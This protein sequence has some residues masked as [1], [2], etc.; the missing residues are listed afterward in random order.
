MKIPQLLSGH[1]ELQHIKIIILWISSFR[2]G[3]IFV[4]LKHGHL[5]MLVPHVYKIEWN[6]VIAIMST[7]GGCL[8][9]T[10]NIKCW[11]TH[12]KQAE[13]LKRNNVHIHSLTNLLVYAAMT[14]TSFAKKVIGRLAPHHLRWIKMDKTD[15]V[16]GWKKRRDQ[17]RIAVWFS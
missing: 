1:S 13:E 8:I 14:K 11:Y 10:I 3:I 16:C 2:S 12:C 6:Y 4:T 17:V 15:C 5:T 7:S 9:Q